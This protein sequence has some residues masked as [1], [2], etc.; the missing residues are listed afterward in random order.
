MSFEIS[1]FTNR[2]FSLKSVKNACRD[3]DVV[4]H[5]ASLI[6]IPQSY[7]SPYAYLETNATGALNLFEC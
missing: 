6:A 4:F 7:Y 2:P 5:L 1:T 3:I